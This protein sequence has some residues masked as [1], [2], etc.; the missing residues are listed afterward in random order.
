[1]EGFKAC[2]LKHRT[3]V[4]GRCAVCGEYPVQEVQLKTFEK[5]SATLKQAG[6]AFAAVAVTN[7]LLTLLKVRP[8]LL[9]GSVCENV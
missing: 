1:M 9:S 6:T 2:K 7:V 3:D 4:W 8:L 5:F